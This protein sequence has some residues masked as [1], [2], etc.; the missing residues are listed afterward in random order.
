MKD[1]IFKKKII[2]P[3]HNLLILS[4]FMWKNLTSFVRLNVKYSSFLSVFI[5]FILFW[6]SMIWT[7]YVRLSLYV[8]FRLISLL[9]FAHDV[10]PSC[11]FQ[12]SAIQSRHT[13]AI[14][15]RAHK[16]GE[17]CLW[18]AF[19]QIHLFR[20]SLYNFNESEYKLLPPRAYVENI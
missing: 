20:H 17:N 12:F 2:K 11:F 19:L 6:I 14:F 7:W 5:S 3:K 18:K 15:L 9:R 1:D 4:C 16:K 13:F 8:K 10:A